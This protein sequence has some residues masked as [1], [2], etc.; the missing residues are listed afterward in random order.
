MW[1]MRKTGIGSME[2]GNELLIADANEY[3]SLAGTDITEQDDET[4]Y[5]FYFNPNNL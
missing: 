2:I 4:E 1:K 5:N 3:A